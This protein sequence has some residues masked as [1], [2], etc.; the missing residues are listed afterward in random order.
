M[1]SVS[2]VGQRIAGNEDLRL[3]WSEPALSTS[4][5]SAEADCATADARPVVEGLLR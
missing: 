1:D 2:R 3:P 5:G 4:L